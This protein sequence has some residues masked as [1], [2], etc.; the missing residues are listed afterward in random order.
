M[1]EK[2]LK[3]VNIYSFHEDNYVSLND[4]VL[5]QQENEKLNHYTLLYQKV[6]ERN[7]NAIEYI[8]HINGGAICSKFNP[9][10]NCLDNILK[11]NNEEE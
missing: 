9:Y 8:Y 3:K 5:L 1:S 11:G 10:L 4:Y 6:K 7:D 2:K